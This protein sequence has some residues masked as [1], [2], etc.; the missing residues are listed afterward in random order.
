MT[1]PRDAPFEPE[2]LWERTREPVFWI[3]AALRLAWVNSAWETLTGYP[4]ET[5]IGLSC[6]AHPGAD[7]DNM[8]LLAA[9]F[10]PPPE[11]LAGHPAGTKA[12]I[13]HAG[14]GESWHRLEFW[15]FGDEDGGLLGLLGWVR[16]AE[17][18]PSV[19]D[20]RA[21]QLRVELLEV[22]QQLR[23]RAGHARL[24]GF[25]PSHRR[26]LEQVRLAA[27]ST[28]A[29]L[30]VGEPGT[31]K[32]HVA[33]AIHQSGAGH[34]RV[35]I[36]FDCESLPGEVL[37]RE[38]FR[39]EKHAGPT[40]GPDFSS[41]G[42]AR[43]RLSLADGQTVLIR[44]ILMLPRDLQLRLVAALDGPVR[45]LATTSSDPRT[46]L[47]DERIRPELYFALTT[48]VLRLDPLRE[49]RDELPILAQHL[50]ERAVERGGETRVGF[51]ADAIAALMAYDWPGNLRELARVID[52]ARSQPRGEGSL[53]ALDDLP[54]SVRG[55]LGAGFTPP[56]PPAPIKPLDELLI[57]V[58]RRAIETAVRLA[59][60]NKSRAAELLGISRPRL[61]RRINEL[62]LPDDADPVADAGAPG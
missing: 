1:A 22:K 37:E 5:V 35:L 12:L 61:Y 25:G 42:V 34:S 55:N 60:G 8:A 20:S 19:P 21:N 26:L 18:A 2:A 51:R 43:P 46:A 3:D 40:A 14:G 54:A 32:R 33:R 39:T 30:I 62:N 36:P 24:I 29:V 58:E 57:A 15:P 11:S 28:A 49:R 31:G 16:G 23:E 48:L 6:Q 7:T 59:R 56:N 45:L 52:H 27:A 53:V 38:L 4:A 9:S 47:E 44:E 10:R 13:H 41:G 17:S 50:L